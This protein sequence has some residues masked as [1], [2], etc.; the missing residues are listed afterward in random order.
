MKRDGVCT[1]ATGEVADM[2]LEYLQ[3]EQLKLQPSDVPDQGRW[4]RIRAPRWPFNSEL[5]SPAESHTGWE[6]CLCLRL[7]LWLK[8]AHCLAPRRRRP[9]DTFLAWIHRINL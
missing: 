1:A 6:Y 5:V 2:Q 8:R 9:T 3:P 4:P 7:T